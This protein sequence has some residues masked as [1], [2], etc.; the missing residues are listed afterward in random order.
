MRR[1]KHKWVHDRSKVKLL[2]SG[3]AIVAC[4]SV[5]QT[6]VPKVTIL[7]LTLLPRR[8]LASQSPGFKCY[9]FLTLCLQ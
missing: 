9:H 8:D 3:S 6:T 4:D 7:V 2:I 5:H 1:L